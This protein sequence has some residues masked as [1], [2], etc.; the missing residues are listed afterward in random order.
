MSTV[1]ER[2]SPGGIG[3][4]AGAMRRFACTQCGAC[5]N[6][7]PEVEL[8][9][10]AGLAD[11]F[12]FRLMFRIYR[13][14]RTF[15]GSSASPGAGARSAEAFYQKKRL[16]ARCA[17]RRSSVKTGQGRDAVEYL[18]YLTLSALTLDS[19]L[20]AC[21]ALR[22]RR[23]G[24]HERRPL[25]CRTVPF[26]YSRVEA[27]AGADLD[28]FVAR[29]GHR[30]DSSAGAALVIEGGRIVDRDY[31]AARTAA[32]ALVE[33][34]RKWQQAIVRQMRSGAR[35][36]LLPGLRDVE[37][38]AVHGATTTSMSVAWRIAVEEGLIGPEDCR[39]LIAAQATVIDRELAGASG[40]V[41]AR[42]TLVEMRREYR[43]LLRA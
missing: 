16:L 6:R 27:V 23:C 38:N 1:P 43:Q 25:S 7:S 33:Q 4:A 30:C 18:Q 34:D 42:E 31:R 12:V 8:S 40:A 20:L 37:A 17:A 2:Q 22:G 19:G 10:A 11:V 21:S 5:C 3:D 9:E 35:N 15:A 13:L 26:H 32:L 39:R 36:G 24:I 41:A 14:P 28:A 29:P